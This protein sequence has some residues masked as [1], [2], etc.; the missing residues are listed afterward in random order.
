MGR[1]LLEF[2][3]LLIIIITII[4]FFVIISKLFDFFDNK[5]S[6]IF[7]GRIGFFAYSCF[8]FLI[9]LSILGIIVIFICWVGD[10]YLYQPLKQLHNSNN[11][12]VTI[13]LTISFFL[14][15]NFTFSMPKFL[16]LDDKYSLTESAR[17]T[18][19]LISL[20]AIAFSPA[21][22][23]WQSWTPSKTLG[24]PK[25][26]SYFAVLVG[27]FGYWFIPLT[28]IS[29]LLIAFF[30]GSKCLFNW[31]LQPK[32]A[33]FAKTTPN[34]Y[35]IEKLLRDEKRYNH[36]VNKNQSNYYIESSKTINLKSP[37]VNKLQDIS[38]KKTNK[39]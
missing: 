24:L 34:H 15:N 14:I 19:L 5:F 22:Y 11:H 39:L 17:I 12:I 29:M 25:D 38:F 3:F 33:N 1:L 4:I 32:S 10:A 7:L 27:Y 30:R 36:K 6:K 13:L 2:L 8:V 28:I 31:M 37:L 9:G 20:A 23:F 26:L 35:D 18:Q 21:T 16:S